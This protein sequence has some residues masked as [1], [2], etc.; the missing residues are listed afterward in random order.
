MLITLL[1]AI[2]LLTGFL[3]FLKGTLVKLLPLAAS[4]AF[5]ISPFAFPQY[6]T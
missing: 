5:P 6:K 2:R 1:K 4:V 3:F